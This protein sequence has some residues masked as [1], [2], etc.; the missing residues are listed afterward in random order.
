MIES[1]LPG[2]AALDLGNEKIFVAVPNAPVRSFGAFSSDLR[3]LS[4]WLK[5][6]HVRFVAMEATGV[7]WINPYDHLQGEGFD[8]T[9]FHGA[10][11]RNLPGRKSDVQDC[12]WHAMLHSHGLLQ[13]CFVPSEKILKLRSFC[14]LRDDH[15]SMASAHIQHMQR[16]LDLLNVRVH[17]VISQI[18]GVSGLRIV[19]AILAGVR[20]P[21]ALA[22]LCDQRILN[23][24]R[25]E[26]VAS[27][28]G[29][30]QKHH[31]F[32]LKHAHEAYSFYQKQI[33][34]CDKE[35]EAV[36]KELNVQQP[37]PQRAEKRKIKITRHNP[38]KID[39]LYGELLT[40]CGGHDAQL[41][42]AM[43]PLTWMKLVG[44]LGTDLSHW[45]SEKHFT[46]WLGLSPGRSRSG[47]RSRRIPRRKTRAGQ[48]FRE[49]TM[50]LALSKDCALGE[51]YRRIRASRGAPVAV[52]AAARKLA[53]LYWRVMVKGVAYV[54][55]GLAEYSKRMLE[56]SER[57]LRRK[58]AKLGY[59]LQAMP[60]PKPK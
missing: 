20:D 56:Q 53:E 27:L 58:A 30:W 45:K 40:A 36:L 2:F 12:Q 48:I 3:L 39:D 32:A 37:A 17:T 7:I 18:H 16:A 26:L 38:P 13:P 43:G 47:K 28:E 44:E 55:Q 8:V 6:N 14:R 33:I 34:E 46:G 11:A 21:E 9:L 15:L 54:E 41:L 35:I 31:L 42:P 49:A 59:L 50:S 10:H 22:D 60:T 23:K 25:K 51:F 5:E 29:N 19:A 4:A 1:I 57:A 24:K 52:V